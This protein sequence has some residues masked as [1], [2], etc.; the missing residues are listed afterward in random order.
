MNNFTV[1]VKNELLAK[2]FLNRWFILILNQIP[3]GC[4]S[5]Y[6]WYSRVMTFF[7]L[8]G[9]NLYNKLYR[10]RKLREGS[11]WTELDFV[12]LR[13]S[14]VFFVSLGGRLCGKL[15]HSVLD[16]LVI[17]RDPR[18]HSW[19]VLLSAAV[20]PG[21]DAFEVEAPWYVTKIIKFWLEY[22]GMC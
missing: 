17:V 3:A 18:V 2:K 6:F 13:I 11:D 14:L 4:Y 16:P 21:H 1:F 15:P 19:T 5:I 8:L 7:L 20:T 22:V 12:S 10:T 9:R